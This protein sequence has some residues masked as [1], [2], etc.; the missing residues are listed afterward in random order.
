MVQRVRDGAEYAVKPGARINVAERHARSGS[1]I[2]ARPPQ[3]FFLTAPTAAV[4]AG[5][6]SPDAEP[7]PRKRKE[8]RNHKE[9]QRIQ[10]SPTPVMSPRL[11]SKPEVVYEREDSTDERLRQ[12]AAKVATSSGGEYGDMASAHAKPPLPGQCRPNAK[13]LQRF[14]NIA[15]TKIEIEN[16]DMALRDRRA[17]TAHAHVRRSFMNAV[18]SQTSASCQRL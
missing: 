5:A 6:L 13:E 16:E 8:E 4:A 9:G 14:D 1:Q 3:L 7:N 12:R 18:P 10:R 15:Q 2:S 11:H 17:E